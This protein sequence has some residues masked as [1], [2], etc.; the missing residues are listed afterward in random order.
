MNNCVNV[1]LYDV[2]LDHGQLQ[3]HPSTHY[4]TT[5]VRA[6]FCW[7][8]PGANIDDGSSLIIHWSSGSHK[9]STNWANQYHIYLGTVLYVWYSQQCVQSKTMLICCAVIDPVK[10][11]KY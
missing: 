9:R 7:W 10:S 6:G 11:S 8:W 2:A 5:N 1:H 4:I 3:Q